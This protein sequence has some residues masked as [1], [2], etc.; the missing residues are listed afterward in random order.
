MILIN[1]NKL[2]GTEILEAIK[3]FGK[4]S[5]HPTSVDKDVSFMLCNQFKRVET[6]EDN[7]GNKKKRTKYARY[8]LPDNYPHSDTEGQDVLLRWCQNMA[9]VDGKPG[10]FRY[11]PGRIPAFS[12]ANGCLKVKKGQHDLFFF[13][14][15]HPKFEMEGRN[16]GRGSFMM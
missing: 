3:K 16:V 10:H 2:S 14:I 6:V 12:T 11:S 9:P 4:E 1:N 8:E 7:K 5:G 13:M 15:N